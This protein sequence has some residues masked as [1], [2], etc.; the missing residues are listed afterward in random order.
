MKTIQELC[1]ERKEEKLQRK[2]KKQKRRKQL[3]EKKYKHG[4]VILKRRKKR[5]WKGVVYTPLRRYHPQNPE[6]LFGTKKDGTPKQKQGRKKGT[7]CPG[8][9][10]WMY[11]TP[12][13]FRNR[14]LAKRP[15]CVNHQERTPTNLLGAGKCRKPLTMQDIT[16]NLG[17]T[18]EILD[19]ADKISGINLEN[20][21]EIEGLYS[22]RSN[23][24]SPTDKLMAVAAYIVKGSIGKAAQVVNIQR[25]T[26][27]SWKQSAWWPVLAGLIQ[28]ERHDFLD[29]KLTGITEK[30]LGIVED[31]LEH[32]DKRVDRAGNEIRVPLSGAQAMLIA[33]KAVNNQSKLKA[34]VVAEALSDMADLKAE[35]KK[36]A[37]F[38]V[39][40]EVPKEPE[41]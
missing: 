38:N 19:L 7:K 16:K 27:Q 14:G 10:P 2:K 9:S 4:L 35:F 13:K 39:V 41:E 15:S 32:G 18:K 1:K 6:H 33:D 31:S 17:E 24:Y 21:H 29:S 37:N 34:P 22:E 20:L 30:A 8:V 23:S 25:S 40:K 12:F 3:Q 26:V 11:R 5:F 36:M 28:R